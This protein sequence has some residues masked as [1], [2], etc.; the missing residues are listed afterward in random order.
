[1]VVPVNSA[2]ASSQRTTGLGD[3]DAGMLF[4]SWIFYRICVAAIIRKGLIAA[5]FLLL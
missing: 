3:A 4:M 5:V 1:V 2:M